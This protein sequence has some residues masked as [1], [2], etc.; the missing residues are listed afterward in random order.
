MVTA[1]QRRLI[2]IPSLLMV[3]IDSGVADAAGGM[4]CVRVRVREQLV[5]ARS[6]LT[7]GSLRAFAMTAAGAIHLVQCATLMVL[8]VFR[9]L[10]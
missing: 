8:L 9:K 2:S 6:N 4:D 1:V 5:L 3:R 7:K 10:S